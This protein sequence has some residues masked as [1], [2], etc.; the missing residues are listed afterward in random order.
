MKTRHIALAILVWACT[1]AQAEVGQ[2]PFPKTE[3]GSGDDVRPTSPA[4][5]VLRPAPAIKWFDRSGFRYQWTFWHLQTASHL[6]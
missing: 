5:D 2:K 3:G 6:P 1:L 4:Q